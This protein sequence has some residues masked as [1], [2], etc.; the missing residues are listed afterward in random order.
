[1]AKAL[2]VVRTGG[3]AALILA[4]TAGG[5]VKMAAVVLLALFVVHHVVALAAGFVA[6]ALI[7]LAFCTWVDRHWDGWEAKA[8]PR[9][10]K[11]ID[12]WRS[13]R[14]MRHIAEWI[15]GGNGVVY[16]IA[17][18]IAM[19]FTDAV[20]VVTVA[21]MLSGR[22]LGRGR[23]LWTCLAAATAFTIYAAIGIYAILG[24]EHAA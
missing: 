16:G 15:T 14:V 24:I 6:Y 5:E 2:G 18:L 10:R 8:G 4:W 3:M 23:V 13:G 21:R 17:S 11:K 7:E 19:F 12:K 1:M 22:K 9:M 20:V